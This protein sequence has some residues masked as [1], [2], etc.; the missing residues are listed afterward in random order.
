M[1]NSRWCL[2]KIN[3]HFDIEAIFAN[4]DWTVTI[5]TNITEL[6]RAICAV[7]FQD[8]FD[9]STEIGVD[10]EKEKIVI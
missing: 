1:T 6:S 2:R 10:A 4:I 7:I 8:T 3:I 9:Q 5:D